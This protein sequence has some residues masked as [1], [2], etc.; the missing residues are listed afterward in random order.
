M[1]K[2]EI[3]RIQAKYAEELMNKAHVV[4]V[5]IGRK[6]G[7]DELCLVVMVDKH[8]PPEDLPIKD[9]I[10][11]EIEGVLVDIRETGMFTAQ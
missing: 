10:P 9:R 2:E 6:P 4:G 8:I 11:A 1:N 7:T 5:G 3:S